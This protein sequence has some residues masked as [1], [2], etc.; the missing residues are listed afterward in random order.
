M[1]K[2]V[3]KY[4]RKERKFD[5]T[6]QELADAIDVNRVTIAKIELGSTPSAEVMMKIANFFNKDPRDI[7]FTS[8][9][10]NSLRNKN[11]KEKVI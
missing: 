5:M 2:N 6:Q 9:V 10:A 8:D 3:V 1:M 11:S 7:F 4:L